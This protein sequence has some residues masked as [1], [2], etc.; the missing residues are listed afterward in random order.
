MRL[1][2]AAVFVFTVLCLIWVLWG[3][4]PAAVEVGVTTFKWERMGIVLVLYLLT[5]AIRGQRLIWILGHPVRF[6]RMFSIL[7]VGYLAINVMPFRLG[8]FVRPY[9]LA[10]RE[11]VPFGA[12]LAAV[13]V[14]RLL[15]TL[16][17]LVMLLAVAF[18][19]ELPA[20][21]LVVE[22]IDVLATG[23]RLFGGVVVT[24]IV[25]LV[26]VL[27]LGERALRVTDRLPLGGLARRFVEGLRGLPTRPRELAWIVVSTVVIWLV[28]LWSV[29]VSMSAFEGLPWDFGSALTVWAATLAGMAAIPTPGFFG[30]FEAFCAGAV[31]L[32]GADADAARTFAVILH[33]GQ[34]GFTVLCG[35]VF[36]AWEGLSLREVVDQS[37]AAAEGDMPGPEV[38]R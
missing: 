29:Q 38:K 34:F 22:G 12:A 10:E 1:K 35:L 23:Q 27:A 18:W 32:L 4:D 6:W 5:H 20:G 19:V 31:M 9:L 21:A 30:G 17:L 2:I 13:F 14:E 11:G 26:T 33:I 8:E 3:I 37:R 25:G 7:S 28:T 15:D 36:L 24:G 16:M